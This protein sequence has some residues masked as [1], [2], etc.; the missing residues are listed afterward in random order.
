MCNIV[1][2]TSSNA[3][4]LAEAFYSAKSLWKT[5]G[6]LDFVVLVQPELVAS[7][8]NTLPD[9]IG[10][11]DCSQSAINEVLARY[12]TGIL[13][14]RNLAEFEIPALGAKPCRLIHNSSQSTFLQMITL[15]T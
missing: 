14:S 7:F 5:Q 9:P 8:I 10:G 4:T 2:E 11:L 3:Q 15:L 12:I 1:P 13:V 6:L